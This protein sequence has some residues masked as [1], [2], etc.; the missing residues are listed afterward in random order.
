[1]SLGLLSVM[2]NLHGMKALQIRDVPEDL[3]R[4]LKARAALEG[5]S[6]SAYALAELHKAVRRPTRREVLDRI[7]S[8]SAVEPDPVPAEV[9]R[10]SRDQR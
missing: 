3:H 10:Q 4:R 6:L 1:M 8:R 9:V 5:L 2:C 7:A